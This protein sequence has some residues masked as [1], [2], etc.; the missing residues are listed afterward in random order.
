VKLARAA[1]FLGP[2]P[3]DLGSNA[4]RS[5]DVA[6]VLGLTCATP[7][8]A[9][10]VRGSLDALPILS[11]ALT[12]VLVGDAPASDVAAREFVRVLQPG[13]AAIVASASRAW[14]EALTRAGLAVE[15]KGDVATARKPGGDSF[16]IEKPSL[17]S[18]FIPRKWMERRRN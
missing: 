18:M 6:F 11:G 17:F 16:E 2:R 14:D 3:A 5:L 15:R 13:G 7:A 1:K 12:G 9:P 4:A 8:D 10:L